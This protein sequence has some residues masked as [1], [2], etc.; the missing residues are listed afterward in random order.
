[1]YAELVPLSEPVSTGQF[2]G[3]AV[4]I[5]TSGVAGVWFLSWKISDIKTELVERVAKLEVGQVD[6]ERRVGTLEHQV[7]HQKSNGAAL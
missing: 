6:T 1:L 4:G 7:F 3:L 2:I 5:F